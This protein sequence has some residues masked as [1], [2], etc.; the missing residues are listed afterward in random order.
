MKLHL[1]Q[2]GRPIITIQIHPQLIMTIQGD[3]FPVPLNP[4]QTKTVNKNLLTERITHEFDFL[5]PCFCGPVHHCYWENVSLS[6]KD[7][8][9]SRFSKTFHFFI[10]ICEKLKVDSLNTSHPVDWRECHSYSFF[11]AWHSD[12]L[13][14]YSSYILE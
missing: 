5:K 4:T 1:S 8:K 2:V 11:F 12:F 13:H 9:F 3:P 6:Q 7:H 10:L 14:M